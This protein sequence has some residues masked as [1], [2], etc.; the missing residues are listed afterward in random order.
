MIHLIDM[1]HVKMKNMKTDGSYKL[2]SQRL[3]ELYK[4]IYYDL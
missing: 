4:M 1:I 2:K 3:L